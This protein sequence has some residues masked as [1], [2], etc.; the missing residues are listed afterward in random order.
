MFDDKHHMNDENDAINPCAKAHTT[1]ARAVSGESGGKSI[2]NEL[3]CD[4]PNT[5]SVFRPSLLPIATGYE[6]MCP[7]DD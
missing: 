1:R 4:G 7:S 5:S 2:R 6:Y 3:I